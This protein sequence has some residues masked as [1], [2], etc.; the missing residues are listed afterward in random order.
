ML[1]EYVP[2]LQIQRELY[3]MPRGYG[4]FRE[5]LRTL[6]SADG[7][8]VRLPSL[9]AMNPMAKEHASALLDQLLAIDADRIAREAVAEA[10]GTLAEVPGAYKV[11]VVLIDDLK[12]GWTDRFATE[13]T[14][15]FPERRPGGPMPR[16]LDHA[17][18]TASI[19]TS[20]PVSEHRVRQAVLTAILRMAYLQIHGP[21]R[22]LRE[23]LAQEGAVLAMAGCDGPTLD[24]DDLDYTRE[25][26]ARLLDCTDMPTSLVALFGDAGGRTL[27]MPPLGFSPNAGL[28][29]ALHDAKA[30]YASSSR[31]R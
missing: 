3:E 12:G 8:G 18:I 16:W 14:M 22:T 1:L 9:V 2:L 15:R 5:Y 28:A 17:W 4:R 13:Y 26:M 21:A 30:S 6:L 31:K 24:D 23:K 20:E 11:G 25:I 7:K 27:G 10:T 29:L 19:W